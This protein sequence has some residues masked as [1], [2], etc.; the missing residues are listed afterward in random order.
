MNSWYNNSL[1]TTSKNNHNFE[2]ANKYK[3][4][5]KTKKIQKNMN[6]AFELCI[7]QDNLLKND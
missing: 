5:D 4:T 3:K 2:N 1:T 6:C 7:Q